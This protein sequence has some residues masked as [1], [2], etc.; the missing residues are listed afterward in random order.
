MA[1]TNTVLMKKM[2]DLLEKDGKGKRG[3]FDRWDFLKVF[4]LLNFGLGLLGASGLAK[5]K[6]EWTGEHWTGNVKFGSLPSSKQGTPIRIFIATHEDVLP[7]AVASLVDL[8]W[9]KKEYRV[10]L[11]DLSLDRDRADYVIVLGGGQTSG[12]QE[13]PY[14]ALFEKS[15]SW[16]GHARISFGGIQGAMKEAME[17]IYGYHNLVLSV[18]RKI[19]GVE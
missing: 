6:I 7:I 11:W 16:V 17:R 5:D 8:L 9:N 13:Y 18:N 19:G 12:R 14:I 15:G 4:L 2:V 3:I 10:L 1:A